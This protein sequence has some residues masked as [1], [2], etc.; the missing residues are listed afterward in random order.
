MESEIVDAIKQRDLAKVKS[1]VSIPGTVDKSKRSETAKYRT[2]FTPRVKA[3]VQTLDS[4]HPIYQHMQVEAMK[5]GETL[6]PGQDSKYTFGTG[7]RRHKK[8]RKVSKTRKNR[9]TRSRRA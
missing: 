3:E 2:L 9:K 7:G 5:I 6:P 8:T 4:K 1:L